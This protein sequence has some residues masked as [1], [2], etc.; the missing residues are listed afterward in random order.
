M[1]ELFDK[2]SSYNLFNYL[3]PG[4]LFA[5]LANRVTSYR[6]LQ[7][8]V[9]VGAF[10]YYFIGLVISRVGSLVLEPCFQSINFVKFAPYESFVSVSK[11]DA[12][13]EL[14][15][16]VNNMY[17]TLCSL[18]TLL[19]FLKIYELLG[20]QFPILVTLSPYILCIA[21]LGMFAFAYRKQTQ[22]IT[23]RINAARTAPD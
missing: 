22:Y 4:V 11:K 15:S 18:F 20:A 1:K 23:K 16:E 7:D 13:L 19:V 17:R 5:A 2:I 21:L 12:K 3:F 6:F 10:V 8:D 14:F 9:I